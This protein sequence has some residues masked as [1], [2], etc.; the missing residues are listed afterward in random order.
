MLGLLLLCAGCAA[1]PLTVTE[2]AETVEA[3]VAEMT[4]AFDEIDEAWEAQPPTLGRALGYW[5]RRLE[6]REQFLAAI[7]ELDPPTEITAIH[8]AALDVFDRITTAD[9]NLAAR[10]AEYDTITTH[11]QWLD[12]PE[13][14]AAQ[15]VLEEVYEFCRLSQ[16]EFDATAER[17]GL[18]DAPWLPP[19]MKEAVKVAFGCPEQ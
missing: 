3:L 13:G 16:E 15:A 5:E 11:R 4:A 8:A 19:D 17:E 2:Y 10:V 18:G 14:A 12:T 9:R 7:Q 6:I 1:A